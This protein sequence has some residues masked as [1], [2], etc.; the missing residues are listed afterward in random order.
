M[1]DIKQ[2]VKQEAK[3][4]KQEIK[5]EVN[6]D[7]IQIKQEQIKLEKKEG[8]NDLDASECSE[9][10]IASKENQQ[11]VVF[12][13]FDPESF[14]VTF[15]KNLIGRF[16]VF[17]EMLEVEKDEN[18][19]F[20]RYWN[21]VT[22]EED[23]KGIEQGKPWGA[24]VRTTDADDEKN[25]NCFNYGFDEQSWIYYRKKSDILKKYTDDICGT[26]RDYDRGRD[27]GR[28]RD[29]DRGRDRDRSGSRHHHHH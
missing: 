7:K 5:E 6:N 3:E 4:I 14:K 25:V 26:R 18:G 29:Y 15:P 28:G 21:E 2:E 17:W 10:Y 9:D 27:Y 8:D 11:N 24:A 23:L 1:S 22:G 20:K 12:N 19:I 16:K 13:K